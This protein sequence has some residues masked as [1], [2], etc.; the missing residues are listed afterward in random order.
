MRIPGQGNYFGKPKPLVMMKRGAK[1][2][3]SDKSLWRYMSMALILSVFALWRVNIYSSARPLPRL[4]RI[5]PTTM[6][7]LNDAQ[8]DHY[9]LHTE[10]RA[11]NVV[12]GYAEGAAKDPRG[13][14]KVGLSKFILSLV[15][16]GF[17]GY[18][19]LATDAS[20]D[21]QQYLINRF[22]EH[23]LVLFSV[24]DLRIGFLRDLH[25][26]ELR[27]YM[28]NQWSRVFDHPDSRVFV[29]DVRDVFFQAN[30]FD[31]LYWNESAVGTEL[32]FF[33]EPVPISGSKFNSDWI[34]ACFGKDV[35]NQ[36]E[37][38]TVLCSGTSAGSPRA[39]QNYTA[40]MVTEMALPS[41]KNCRNPIHDQ[42]FHNF[43][44]YTNRFGYPAHLFA[45]GEGPAIN[46]AIEPSYAYFENATVLNKDGNP[47]ALVHQYDR[48]PQVLDVLRRFMATIK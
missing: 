7:A 36:I 6:V 34:K 18:I 29:T 11:V 41:R 43:L 22:S 48:Q 46:L 28:Y 12:M 40:T 33:E 5:I 39:I 24:S 14:G 47:A 17:S 44:Y 8:F 45:Q 2:K 9:A 4:T 27:Y 15:N 31:S 25:P 16:T 23:K 21:I 38:Q 35:L 20:A 37:M 30:P 10:T 19:I 13:Y 1:R 3:D 26:K 32:F 42:S